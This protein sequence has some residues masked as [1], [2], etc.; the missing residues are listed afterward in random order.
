MTP[1]RQRGKGARPRRAAISKFQVFPAAANS[2]LS[3]FFEKLRTVAWSRCQTWANIAKWQGNPAPASQNA[4]DLHHRKQLFQFPGRQSAEVHWLV[5]VGVTQNT[6][7]GAAV[8]KT[9]PS[10]SI[11][12]SIPVGTLRWI[13]RDDP[14]PAQCPVCRPPP[15][16]ARHAGYFSSDRFQNVLSP[17]TSSPQINRL[18]N[19]TKLRTCRLRPLSDFSTLFAT[20]VGVASSF[21]FK[22]LQR[23]PS[24]G[25]K[26]K[27]A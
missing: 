18:Q 17:R 20:A 7:P 22:S 21:R 25:T 15:I 24:Q 23:Q 14:A 3:C 11:Q 5:T 9:A 8:K 6:T 2:L 16:A 1:K 27:L 26:P 10:N 13:Q 12:R 19:R 4:G